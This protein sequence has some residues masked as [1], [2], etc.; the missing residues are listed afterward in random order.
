[1]RKAIWLKDWGVA[2]AGLFILVGCST[3]QVALENPTVAIAATPAELPTQAATRIPTVSPTTVATLPA[4]VPFTRPSPRNRLGE[5]AFLSDRETVWKLYVMD[6]DGS[7]LHKLSNLP[8][9]IR[10]DGVASY[11]WSPNGTRL[12]FVSEQDSNW[13][14]Y[15]INDDGTNLQRLIL[16]PPG[17]PAEAKAVLG[18]HSQMKPRAC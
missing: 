3:A 8:A 2:L 1:M 6:A 10:F 17:A 14:I 15:S 7:N 13:Q 16:L 5:I 4:P 12:A 11:S 9:R 18:A